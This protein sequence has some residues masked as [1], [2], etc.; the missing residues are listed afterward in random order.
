MI[1][2]IS[3]VSA[4]LPPLPFH[5]SKLRKMSETSERTTKVLTKPAPGTV[6]SPIHEYSEEQQAQIKDLKQVS[7]TLFL[8]KHYMST[9]FPEV[10]RVVATPR[11]RLV[12]PMGEALAEQARYHPSVHARGEV[13]LC[14]CAET[15]KGD[16]G[17]AAGV[18]ARSDCAGRRG[19]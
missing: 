14:R 12:S 2:I 3:H 1:G 19:G 18:Q 15:D 4:I 9:D 16:A 6:V 10:R 7:T 17:V 11:V 5:S 8:P 13:A